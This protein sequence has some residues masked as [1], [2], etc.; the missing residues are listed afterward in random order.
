MYAFYGFARN[1][2]NQY[3][4][5]AILKLTIEPLLMICAVITL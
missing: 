3:S 1:R 5:Y 2:I 4:L